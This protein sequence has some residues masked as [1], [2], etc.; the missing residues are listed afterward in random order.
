MGLHLKENN[1]NSNRTLK[2]VEYIQMAFK[3]LMT[4]NRLSSFDKIIIFDFIDLLTNIH[5][6]DYYRLAM[7]LE[8]INE[9][10]Q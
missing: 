8:V 7:E 9:K 5:E 4:P 3:D 10:S 2:Q 1:M 6:L